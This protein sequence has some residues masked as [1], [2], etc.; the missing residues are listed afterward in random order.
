MTATGALQAQRAAE[1][2]ADAD[3]TSAKRQLAVAQQELQAALQEQDALACMSNQV[4]M[5]ASAG[6]RDT[7]PSCC[8]RPLGL[9]TQ[10]CLQQA[11][12]AF[13]LR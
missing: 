11:E 3:V 10:V 4:R 12:S 1:R 5:R 2:G 6:G 9:Q 8:T 13:G 7:F